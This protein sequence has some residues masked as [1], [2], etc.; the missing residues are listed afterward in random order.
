MLWNWLWWWWHLSVMEGF[1]PKME[2]ERGNKMANLM[3]A[4]SVKQN[5]RT[6]TS[7]P[8]NLIIDRKLKLNY[9][10]NKNLP[11][12]SPHS[13]VSDLAAGTLAESPI[14][15]SHSLLLNAAWPKTYQIIHLICIFQIAVSLLFT[16]K[17][18]F[19]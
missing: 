6:K 16:N 2:L 14:H 11:R 12:I 3:H 7:I 15:S 8:H 17:L 13:E 19:W 18:N 1:Q 9:L 5:L 10:T 4:T